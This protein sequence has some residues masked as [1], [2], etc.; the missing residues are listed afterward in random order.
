MTRTFDPTLK[1]KSNRSK[2]IIDFIE[3]NGGILEENIKKDT[4][5]LIVKSY[6]DTSSKTEY[7]KK[8]GIP[9]LSVEDFKTKYSI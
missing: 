9:I 4:F 7:A 5:L 6:E 2:A 1:L 3:K 8:H